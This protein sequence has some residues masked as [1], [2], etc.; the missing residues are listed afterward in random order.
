MPDGMPRRGSGPVNNSRY[1]DLLGVTKDASDAEIKKAHRKMALQYHPDK[2]GSSPRCTQALLRARECIPFWSL[3]RAVRPSSLST[4][5]G[6]C[7]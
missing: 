7:I 4:A 1:Y 3:P 2:G 5:G 6:P